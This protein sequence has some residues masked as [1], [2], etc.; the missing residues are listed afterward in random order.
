MGKDAALFAS[1]EEENMATKA[2][3]AGSEISIME[4]VEG[5]MDF[6]ILGTS[7]FI[8]NRM[9]QKAWFELLA[10][11]KKTA[12]DKAANMKH[13]PLAEFRNSPYRMASPTAPTVLAVTPTSFKKAMGTAA[14]ETPGA[15][16]AQIGR[17]VSV[18]WDCM[19]I[20][21]VPKVFMAITRSA[22]MNKTP[23]VRTRAII[24]EWACRLTVRFQKPI[25]REQSLA[26]LLAAAGRLS[27]VGDWRQEKGSGSYGAFK[28]VSANDKDFLRIINTG[29]RAAQQE[30]LD[31]PVAYNDETSEMLAWF[32]VELKRR[33][34]KVAA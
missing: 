13:D 19:P 28:L 8:C 27:G 24:P 32:E 20:W 18:D 34:F 12:A 23:D 11:Q 31:N 17:L 3:I 29:G 15:K 33:G 2:P 6:C 16:K 10:P 7:P 22:D 5:Q 4:V 25:L 30:A 9:S 1:N 21:G 14:L 26:N